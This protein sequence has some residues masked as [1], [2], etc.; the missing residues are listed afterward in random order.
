MKREEIGKTNN[1][2]WYNLTIIK[3]ELIMIKIKKTIRLPKLFKYEKYKVITD[4]KKVGCFLAY[5]NFFHQINKYIK[6]NEKTFNK[7]NDRKYFE[8]IKNY[9]N[10]AFILTILSGFLRLLLVII[11]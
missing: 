4:N 3:G 9:F 10:R 1:I 5:N 11:R 6:Y 2:T 8:A 7:L